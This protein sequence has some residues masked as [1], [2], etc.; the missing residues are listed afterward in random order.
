MTR[1][2]PPPPPYMPGDKVTVTVMGRL[3]NAIVDSVMQNALG[4]WTRV[5]MTAPDGSGRY[6]REPWE[7]SRGWLGEGRP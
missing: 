3:R 4:E 2:P 1:R 7:V 6:V 5:S